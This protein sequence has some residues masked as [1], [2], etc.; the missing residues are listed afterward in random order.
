M[1]DKRCG[2]DTD[3]GIIK[4][5]KGTNNFKLMEMQKFNQLNLHFHLFIGKGEFYGLYC[6]R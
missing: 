2:V 3:N 5:E 1:N 6:Y 4:L